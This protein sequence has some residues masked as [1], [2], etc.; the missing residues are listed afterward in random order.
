M[1]MLLLHP[2]LHLPFSARPAPEYLCVLPHLSAR[3]RASLES[4]WG[5]PAGVAPDR[6]APPAD[7]MH[8]GISSMALRLYPGYTAD[9]SLRPCACSDKTAR[10]ASRAA[11]P[12][13][14]TRSQ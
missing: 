5:A 9:S 4:S 7:A 3:W 14:A 12:V 8:T 13:L 2:V 6:A 1:H 10:R 11:A